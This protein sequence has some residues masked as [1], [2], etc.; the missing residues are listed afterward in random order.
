VSHIESFEQLFRCIY[1]D[2]VIITTD[3]IVLL[4]SL[5]RTHRRRCLRLRDGGAAKHLTVDLVD[6]LV[7]PSGLD[8]PTKIGDS[9][10]V[11]LVEVDEHLGAADRAVQ[12]R[13]ASLAHG[14]RHL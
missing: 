9:R 3:V 2:S 13:R 12:R 4:L 1:R 7:P 14:R 8:I 5:C 10:L 6:K 11:R